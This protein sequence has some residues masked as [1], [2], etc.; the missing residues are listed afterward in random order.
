MSSLANTTVMLDGT[1]EATFNLTIPE[2]TSG[3]SVVMVSVNYSGNVDTEGYLIVIHQ[4]GTGINISAPQ[5]ASPGQFIDVYINSTNQ[6]LS[7]APFLMQI[8]RI[9]SSVSIS[10][11]MGGKKSESWYESPIYLR[12]DGVDT[13]M[14]I[15]AKKNTGDY[16]AVLMFIEEDS[17]WYGPEDMQDVVFMDYEV[18]Q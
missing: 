13:H 3:M 14:K 15:L 2:N 10:Q 6:N 17:T 12:K 9:G 18:V 4:E 8:D 1:G 5:T 16:T 7:V 11:M